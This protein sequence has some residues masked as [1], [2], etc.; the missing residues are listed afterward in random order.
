MK[1]PVFLNYCEAEDDTNI[2]SESKILSIIHFEI[3]YRKTCMFFP[4]TRVSDIFGKIPLERAAIYV[5]TER[6]F[7]K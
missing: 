3:L 6:D 4:N 5:C 1:H 7:S 2:T